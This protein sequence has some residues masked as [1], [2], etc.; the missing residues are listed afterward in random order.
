MSQVSR[1]PI[2]KDVY[3]RIIDLFLGLFSS[4]NSKR[5]ASDFFDEFL[6]PTERI[7][8]A[9]RVAIG[10]LLAKKYSYRK[11]SEVLRVSKSTIGVVSSHY[12]YGNTLKKAIAHLMANEGIEKL[13][14][15]FAEMITSAGTFGRKGAS[16]WKYLNIEVKKQIRKKIL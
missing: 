16:G 9:K 7:M 5:K 10:M 13:L 11:I 2:P 4:L 3:D 14:L 12:R 1:Y 8:M 6:T 15:E